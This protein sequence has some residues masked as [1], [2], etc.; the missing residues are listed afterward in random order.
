M[1]ARGT[2][3]SINC[4][5]RVIGKGGEIRRPGRRLGLYTGIFPEACASFVGLNKANFAGR[6][7]VN[8]ERRKQFA[9][10]PQLAGIV[11]RDHQPSGNSTMFI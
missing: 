6:N 8:A 9:H 7:R 3:Q 4:Q 5:P 11:G 1:N 2:V 10:F